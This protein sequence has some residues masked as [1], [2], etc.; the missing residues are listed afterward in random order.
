MLL[1]NASLYWIS[2]AVPPRDNGKCERLIRG[3]FREASR[4]SRPGKFMAFV[5][6][7][8]AEKSAGLCP[9]W[10]YSAG[11][12]FS[13]VRARFVTKLRLFPCAFD[14]AICFCPSSNLKSSGSFEGCVWDLLLSDFPRWSF[15]WIDTFFAQVIEYRWK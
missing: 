12:R 10:E 15:A 1:A 13:F 11:A 6:S 7:R 4:Q 9:R 14:P 5:G 3:F 2:R 8:E